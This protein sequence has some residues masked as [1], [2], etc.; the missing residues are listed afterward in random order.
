MHGPGRCREETLSAPPLGPAA[1]VP[2]TLSEKPSG[3]GFSLR[4][5]ITSFASPWRPPPRTASSPCRSDICHTV[6]STRMPGTLH[7][8]Q[9]SSLG[10][11]G[12][13]R[14]STTA[15]PGPEGCRL[16]RTFTDKMVGRAWRARPRDLDHPVM[17]STAVCTGPRLTADRQCPH[18]CGATSVEPSM[19]SS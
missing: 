13:P 4:D 12:K 10:V 11:Q 18:A 16:P 3:P 9:T 17:T 6:V 1:T 19:L 5:S 2:C 15:Q 14:L 7:G 8:P